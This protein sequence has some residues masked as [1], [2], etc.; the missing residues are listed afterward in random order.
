MLITEGSSDKRLEN[1]LGIKQPQ[2]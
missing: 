2:F 1:R